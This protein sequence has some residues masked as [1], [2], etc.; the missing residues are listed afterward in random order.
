MPTYDFCGSVRVIADDEDQ[1]WAIMESIT[2]I[3]SFH[4]NEV[5]IQD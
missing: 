4:V 2:Q 1:A 5:E 3:D